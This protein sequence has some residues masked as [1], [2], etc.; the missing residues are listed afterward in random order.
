MVENGFND[1]IQL[2]DK[3]GK[4]IELSLLDILDYHGAEYAMLIPLDEGSD[5]AV[6]EAIILRV[7]ARLADGEF[8]FEGIED[9]AT[10]DAVYDEFVSLFGEDE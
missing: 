6:R 7:K 8:E 1:I 4:T 3:E 2:S 10:L 9:V 5:D